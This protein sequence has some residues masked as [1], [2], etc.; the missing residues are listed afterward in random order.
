MTVFSD[1]GVWTRGVE[2]AGLPPMRAR[3]LDVGGFRAALRSQRL[4]PVR[5]AEL[6]TPGGE[7]F[8]DESGARAADA[9]WCQLFLVTQGSTH[10]D[11]DGRRAELR[12]GDLVVVDP[13]RPLTVTTTATRYLTVLMPRH[14]L[15]LTDGDLD[16]V[17]G[18]RIPGSG[19]SGALLSSVAHAAVAAGGS[20]G[21]DE[22]SR[23]GTAVATLTTALLDAHLPRRSDDEL[24]RRRVEVFVEAHLAD[25]GLD[26]STVA[27]AHHISCRR[28]HQLFRDEPL[29]VAALVRHRRLE[30]CRADL[31]TT[32]GSIAQIA[33]RWGFTDP[34]H[35]SRLFRSTYGCTP[36]EH[37]RRS[38]ALISN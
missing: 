3:G 7:C 18:V 2:A 37:R 13:S 10:L 35:F 5:V 24:L 38:A 21:P 6:V 14:L 36:G 30:R 16:R 4:G 25:P 27:A 9:G 19:G 12:G 32:S 26:P 29:T 20:F 22:A 23:S 34:A 17:R 15:A 33:A 8:R 11:Q 31:G 28:L 1:P